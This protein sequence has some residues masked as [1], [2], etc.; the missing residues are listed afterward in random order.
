MVNVNRII[1]NF[2]SIVSLDSPSHDERLVCEYLKD[3]L[4]KLGIEAYEDNSGEKSGGTTGNLYAFIEGNKNL[5]PFVFSSHMDTVEPSKNKCAIIH[6][7]G[8]IT[9]KGDTVLGS[10]DVAGIV[11]ILEAL[12]VIKENNLSHRPIELLFTVSEETHCGGSSFFDYSKL[13]SKQAFVFD[14]DGEVGG[15]ASKAPTI[16]SY[17][18]K[19]I[20][21]SAHAAFAAKEGIHAIKAAA[22]AVSKIP[23]GAIAEEMTAN[24][25]VIEGGKATNIV[26]DLCTIKG[27][28]RSFDDS[29][30]LASFKGVEEICKSSAEELGARVEIKHEIAVKAFNVDENSEVAK[31]FKKCCA[32]LGLS[33]ELFETFGGSDNNV[34]AEHGVEGLVVATG[35]NNCHSVDEYTSVDQLETAAR[36][37]LE[38]MLS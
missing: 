32:A 28:I 15:A 10:D 4:K 12:T 26:P 16:L 27:E 11:S 25:G 36:L 13:K 14:M 30:V 17:E 21:Q 19:F 2:K 6:E 24:I 20:G 31:V 37:A 23:C 38:L 8:K 35:M 9:S 22:L 29:K 34:F 3:Y 33:G 1:E 18:A 5:E 7:N